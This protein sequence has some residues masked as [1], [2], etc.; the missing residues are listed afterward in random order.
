MIKGLI[1]RR[2]TQADHEG[3]ITMFRYLVAGEDTLLS[4]TGVEVDQEPFDQWME[5][6]R[7]S[8]IHG[9]KKDGIYPLHWAIIAKRPD[10]VR[11]LIEDGVDITVTVSK[12][13]NVRAPRIK[14]SPMRGRP[15]LA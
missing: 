10:L 11:R 6:M 8:S 9:R 5:K 14:R 12:G 1:D 3:D 15:H 2:R 13:F 4:G 7:F